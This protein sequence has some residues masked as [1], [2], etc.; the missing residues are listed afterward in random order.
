[1]SENV[2]KQEL[3]AKCREALS[4]VT[5]PGTRKNLLEG[6]LLIGDPQ[7]NGQHVTVVLEFPRSTDPFLKSTVKAAEAAIHY[8]VSPELDVEV[9]TRFKQT[10]TKV[11][12]NNP[13]IENPPSLKGTRIIAVSS[14][15]GGVGKS[16][17]SVN[18][19]IALARL[20]HSVAILDTDV[21][22]PSL[23]KMFH[24]EEDRI[25]AVEDEEGKQRIEPLQKYGVKMLSIGFFVKPTTAT[26]WRGGMATAALKQL[27]TDT[28]WENPDFLILDTPPG[29]G[30]I[31]LTLLQMLHIDGAL[32]VT[33]P[34]QVA[35]ADAR[36]GIDMYQNPKVNVPVLGVVENMSWF[37]PAELPQNK[38]YLF[39]RGGGSLLAQ[40]TGVPLLAQ[41]PI[42]ESVCQDGDDGTPAVLNNES[43]V[44]Q[45][46]LSLAQSVYTLSARKN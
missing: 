6:G 20:G 3:V 37:T 30:D 29:T 14:G 17:V 8:H 35:L 12:S 32:I 16:T 42:V 2:K 1:M 13:T 38:Y 4:H 45:A 34:Q 7:L 24:A 27:I 23:P 40:E 41:I 28:L 25:Y 5:Y 19:A 43:P 15:K 21:L 22:G 11:N 33:T 18:L 36:K 9:Q 46:F 44:A 26:V 10:E 39:G 31:H